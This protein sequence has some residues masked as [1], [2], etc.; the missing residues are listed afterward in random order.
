MMMAY[1]VWIVPRELAVSPI[2]MPEEFEEYSRVF[3]SVVILPEDGELAR[4]R[5]DPREWEIYGVKY[6]HEPVPDFT[7]PRLVQL[8][9]IL[10]WIEERRKE[11]PVLIHC[12]GGVGRSGTVA[13]CY[14]VYSK[15]MSPEKAL[16]KVREKIPEAA[17]SPDQEKAPFL[18][19][20]FVEILGSEGRE[21]LFSTVKRAKYWKSASRV[22]EISLEISL[23]LMEWKRI[24]REEVRESFFV[25][26]AR[27]LREEG[28]EEI[29]C[30]EG[31]AEGIAYLSYS[32]DVHHSGDVRRVDL[33]EGDPIRVFAY[34]PLEIKEIIEEANRRKH[35]LEKELGEKIDIMRY[36]P[37]R[38][39][40]S[41]LKRHH[42]DCQ[43]GSSQNYQ[44]RPIEGKRPLMNACQVISC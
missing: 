16:E 25:S 30:G 24:S 18:L 23:P 27:Y 3:G 14:L 29:E 33:K 13:A 21:F 7:S 12:I 19:K 5:Y 35:V 2:P 9:R 10:D 39:I 38:S 11:G 40:L 43:E 36:W 17:T 6:L 44:K 4:R 42:S 31:I 37:W 15:G 26:G 22:M 20:K 32:L 28:G 34:S 8:L 41:P 1:Y